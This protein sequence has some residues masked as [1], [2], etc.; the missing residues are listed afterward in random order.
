MVLFHGLTR[1][2]VISVFAVGLVTA[3]AGLAFIFRGRSPRAD[4][5][6]SVGHF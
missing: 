6:E 1:T 2:I 5:V 3:I 4:V